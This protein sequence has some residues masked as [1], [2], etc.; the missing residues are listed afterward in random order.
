LY[1][2]CGG[3]IPGGTLPKGER[4]FEVRV[5]GAGRATLALV[6]ARGVEAANA[7]TGD[8]CTERFL[9][10]PDAPGFVRAQL[11]DERGNFLALTNPL[12]FS[13]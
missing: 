3:I 6:S 9:L 11:L 10:S 13:G 12:Y 1:L 2:R 7:M 8:D 4:E 5:L